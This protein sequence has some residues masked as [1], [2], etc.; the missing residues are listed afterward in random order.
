[1]T[2]DS[3]VS[4]GAEGAPHP[5][6]A[7]LQRDRDDL[8]DRLLR[9]MA[10]FD[11]YRKRV[12]RERRDLAEAASLDLIRDLLPI[13]DDFDRALAAPG[14]Q[15]LPEAFRRGME[16]IHRRLLEVLRVRGVE[17]LEVVGV[18]FD[19]A[20]HESIASEPAHGRPEG[21]IVAELRRGYRQGP[22]LVRA[23]QV[24]VTQA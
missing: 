16:L 4:N 21:Q 11:N 18:M 20:W 3:V 1:M 8:Q 5:S 23:A 12:E 13:I 17:P 24:K 10:E 7:A 6:I 15:S 19:P 9:S 14:A 2:D 22:R